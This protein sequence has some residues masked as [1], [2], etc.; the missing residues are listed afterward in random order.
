MKKLPLISQGVVFVLFFSSS[1]DILNVRMRRPGIAVTT[2][3]NEGVGIKALLLPK[4][5]YIQNFAPKNI[6]V[7]SCQRRK[8][9]GGAVLLDNWFLVLF[10][11]RDVMWFVVFLILLVPLFVTLPSTFHAILSY[12]RIFSQK[13]GKKS[14]LVSD[15]VTI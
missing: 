7:M 11:V 14:D 12:R 15:T 3:S 2:F 8:L 9:W 13:W 4:K 5:R 10:L 1:N 6:G